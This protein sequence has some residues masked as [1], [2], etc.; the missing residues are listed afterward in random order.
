MSLRA[1]IVI[2]FII[3]ILTVVVNGIGLYV[4]F[5]LIATIMFSLRKIGVF[6]NFNNVLVVEILPLF[7]ATVFEL[8]FGNFNIVELLI[9]IALRC[10][11]IGIFV[12]DTKAYVY[13][14]EEREVER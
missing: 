7:L 12:Y 2:S 4:I 14:T 5:P 11:F 1:L 13:M 3:F 9:T 6:V 8:I 10:V